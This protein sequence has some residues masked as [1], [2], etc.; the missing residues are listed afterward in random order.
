MAKAV[1]FTPGTGPPSICSIRMTALSAIMSINARIP[2]IAR[3]PKQGWLETSRPAT[4]DQPKGTAHK[5]IAS[6]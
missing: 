4:T 2:K 3:N 1:G 6:R 5:K